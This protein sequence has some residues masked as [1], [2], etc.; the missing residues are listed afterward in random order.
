MEVRFALPKGIFVRTGVSFLMSKVSVP[1]T[2]VT[3]LPMK[4]DF[5]PS[6]EASSRLE[7]N[8][9][10]TKASL[11]ATVEGLLR[12]VVGHPDAP[13]AWIC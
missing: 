9:H 7:G 1:S 6:D 13:S 3:F 12:S 2:G 11:L 5:R 10:T 4:V 8:L